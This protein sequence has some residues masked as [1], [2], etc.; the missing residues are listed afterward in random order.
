MVKPFSKIPLMIPTSVFVFYCWKE[1]VIPM[2]HIERT[3]FYWDWVIGYY[4]HS[5]TN[6]GTWQYP[7]RCGLRGGAEIST[8]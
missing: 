8:V 2:Q 4:V 3:I 1:I 5:I 6:T 7:G